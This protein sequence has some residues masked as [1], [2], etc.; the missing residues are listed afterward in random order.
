MSDQ[1]QSPV[2]EKQIPA[3]D[4]QIQRNSVS[5]E[6]HQKL[7]NEKKKRDEDLRLAREE[8]KKFQDERKIMEETALREKED[9]KKLF[10]SREAELKA[11]REAR[12]GIENQILDSKKM[13]SFLQNVGT[14]IPE[15]FWG[16]IDLDRIA[17]DPATGTIDDVIVKNYADE[18][19]KNYFEITMN[20]G[21]KIPDNGPINDKNSLTY[22]QWLKLP[23][24]EQRK[25]IKDVN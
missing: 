13:R 9:Y 24:S 25:R 1:Q 2:D 19:K 4:A 6:S 8:L 22:E 5:Y 15:K 23:P 11:E 14:P 20:R 21:P 7:L 12:Q 18:F 3:E 17:V 16:L 10:E